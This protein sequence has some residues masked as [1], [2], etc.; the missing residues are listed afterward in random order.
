MAQQALL[1]ETFKIVRAGQFFKV[2]NDKYKF[3]QSFTE[4]SKAE[5]FIENYIRD[6]EEKEFLKA[7]KR[8]HKIENLKERC[9]RYHELCRAYKK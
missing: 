1:R 9:R 4:Y 3:N 5:Q 6:K 7:V 8:L 2:Y